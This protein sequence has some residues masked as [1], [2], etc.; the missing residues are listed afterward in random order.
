[1]RLRTEL[2]NKV[3][4]SK[5]GNGRKVIA[6]KDVNIEIAAGE[7]VGLF[8]ASGSGKSTVGEMVSGLI[9]PNSGNIYYEEQLIKYPF[10]G[11]VRKEI[12]IL[13]QHPEVSFNPEL[14]LIQ[15]ME[16]PYKLY[17]L[18]YSKEI[19]INDIERF[20]LHE[21][22]LYRRPSELSGGELQRAALTRILL[23]EPKLIVLDEPTSMLD[24][25]TQAQ[26]IEMLKQYQNESGA[27][28]LFISHSKTLTEL[29]CDK[30]YSVKEGNVQLIKNSIR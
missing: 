18:P 29:I 10:K 2:L 30:I 16:E 23:L 1:M 12:Q 20:G 19:L 8:G 25:I 14:P 11:I 27:S 9:K 3:Y 7:T 28:F 26:I 4:K 24:V 21:E 6:A 15:S 13:F 22:H 17:N 5:S